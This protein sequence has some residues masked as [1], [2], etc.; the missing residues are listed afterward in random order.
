MASKT[1]A[2]AGPNPLGW[3]R[4][5]A[6]RT[7][8]SHAAPAVAAQ[9]VHSGPLAR[10][11][12]ESVR[13]N[14]ALVRSYSERHS[15]KTEASFETTLATFGLAPRDQPLE[16]QSETGSPSRSNTSG[17]F[18]T[19]FRDSLRGSFRRS[20][21]KHGPAQ[22]A[23][24]KD[25][26]ESAGPQRSFS[27]KWN[28]SKDLKDAQAAAIPPIPPLVSLSASTSS[29]AS[30]C[31]AEPKKSGIKKFLQKLTMK[32]HKETIAV[33]VPEEDSGIESRR[34]SHATSTS[35]L[36]KAD[37]F[38][39]SEGEHQWR[40][41]YDDSHLDLS[42]IHINQVVSEETGALQIYAIHTLSVM[43]PTPVMYDPFSPR[44]FSA[45][46]IQRRSTFG[47]RVVNAFRSRSSIAST[48]SQS[49]TTARPL[50]T[51]S[52]N[53]SVIGRSIEEIVAEDRMRTGNVSLRVPSLVTTAVEFLE[54]HVRATGLFRVPGST[55]RVRTLVEAFDSGASPDLSAIQ[56]SDMADVLKRF[57]RELPDPLLISPLYINFLQLAHVTNP[58]TQLLS[59]R[60]LM[61]ILPAINRET[62][63]VILNLLATVASLAGEE[64]GSKMTASNLALILAP[65]LLRMRS[66]SNPVRFER[67]LTSSSDHG[68]GG[69]DETTEV[70]MAAEEASSV[71][72]MMINFNKRLFVVPA[73]LR[74]EA[75]GFH[76]IQNPQIVSDVIRRL[77]ERHASGSLLSPMN[78]D[79]YY[80][81]EAVHGSAPGRRDAVP[82]EKHL[83][84]PTVENGRVLR[85][86]DA[87]YS[88]GSASDGQ[89]ISPKLVSSQTARLDQQTRL[90][91]TPPARP[92]GV[93]VG[94][95]VS[96][97]VTA[98]MGGLELDDDDEDDDDDELD[99]LGGIDEDDEDEES[100]VPMSYASYGSSQTHS[101]ASAPRP[102]LKLSPRK[103]DPHNSPSYLR[104]TFN[105][106]P[107][108][109]KPTLRLVTGPKRL[110]D[111]EMDEDGGTLV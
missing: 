3:P 31:S 1:A 63:E 110:L 89:L 16:V 52:D 42:D 27:F 60:L 68:Q 13:D 35:S 19:S 78:S 26:N 40:G 104:R 99:E 22:P 51:N 96:V 100:R 56:P 17:S 53:Q 43:L 7:P 94:V 50:S 47:S 12:R 97:P 57:L 34:V 18:R 32:K 23:P 44:S 37:Y 39:S 74:D 38:R 54:Q 95:V 106:P 14:S 41:R 11:T 61:L 79:P 69:P 101:A 81:Y 46:T 15:N 33:Q 92:R 84:V 107:A 85:G 90:P 108:T 91:G 8:S 30:P 66:D 83:R 87:Q 71:V 58:E 45:E 36:A 6:D 24:S 109:H 102:E 49:S 67:K 86:G 59:L 5:A 73:A 25:E 77:L 70:T 9:T 28:R 111:L 93:D 82:K 105:Q 72:E 103:F 2:S 55:K 75:L 80:P 29:A 48:T 98:I 62:L 4:D 20:S 10:A 21:T 88:S 65:N 76:A 64:D